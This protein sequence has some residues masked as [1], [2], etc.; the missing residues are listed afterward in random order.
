MVAI[1]LEQMFPQLLRDAAC[2]IIVFMPH[3]QQRQDGKRRV[4]M[5]TSVPYFLIIK[6]LIVLRGCMPERVV[7]RM[8]GLNQNAAQQV[9]PARASGDLGD[10]LESSFRGTKTRRAR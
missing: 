1:R 4:S 6:S 2:A 8:I 5:I 9:T 10:E 7:M 3:E